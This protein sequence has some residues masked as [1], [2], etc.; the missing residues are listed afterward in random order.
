MRRREF[1]AGLGG[2]AAWPVVARAQQPAVPVIGLISGAGPEPRWRT[3]VEAFRAGLAEAGFIEG[4][5]VSIEYRWANN[6]FGSLPDM[7]ADLVRRQVAVIVAF[8]ALVP[9][10]VAK[11][12][13]STIP[14]V[15]HYFGDPVKDDLVAS[16]SRPGGNVTGVTSN[17]GES[18]GLDGKRLQ[19]LLQLVPQARKV[20]FLSRDKS[21]I[22]YER[23]TTSMLAAGRALGVEIMIVECRSDHDYEAALA[24]M[25]EGRA[26]AMIVGTFVLPNLGKV[27]QLAALHKLP[28]IYPFGLFARAG[29]LMSYEAD[30]ITIFRR[31]GRAYVARILKGD[32]PADIPV[33]QPTKF[34]LVINLWTAKALNLEVPPSLLAVSNE[35]IEY[36]PPRREAG[37]YFPYRGWNLVPTITVVS[38]AGDPRLRLVADAVAF[39]NKTFA[40]LGTPFRLGALTQVVG[41]IPVEDLKTLSS[42]KPTPESL[43]RIAG[44][45]V[46]VLSGS[47]E[48]LSF[49]SSRREALNKVVVAIKDYRS[50]PF[51]LPNVARNVIAHE[52]GRAIGLSRNADPTTLMCGFPASCRPPLF[53]SD[54]AKYFPL[55]EAEKAELEQMY[56]KTWQASG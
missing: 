3:N 44:N 53:A 42:L 10:R 41:T 30:E 36:E 20:A 14:I 51:T 37:E 2:A 22:F 35:V 39:W 54:R 32:R 49:T 1:I 24:K 9:V 33:E 31:L 11:A 45:I 55:T 47:S 17:A 15:F 40:Q 43:N 4:K 52:L 23:F 38:P 18:G 29:G 21:A 46:V 13:A 12:I 26:D 5:N 56:P 48:F 16:L 50:F 28:T 6:D 34:E 8:G 27:V 25:V 7:A 19:L